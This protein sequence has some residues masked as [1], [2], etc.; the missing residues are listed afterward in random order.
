M[1]M[2]RNYIDILS[3]KDSA[4]TQTNLVNMCASTF[5]SRQLGNH[6]CSTGQISE[7]MCWPGLAGSEEDLG[8]PL[9]P[10]VNWSLFSLEIG[11]YN[12]QRKSSKIITT[13]ATVVHMYIQFSA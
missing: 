1:T 13:K 7:G 8:I 2:K 6:V 11:L 10:L 9:I 4:V 3:L 12:E 5:P